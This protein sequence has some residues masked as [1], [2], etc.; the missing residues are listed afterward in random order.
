ME[1][2]SPNKLW[3]ES[4][5]SL[6]FADWIEREKNKGKFMVNKKFEVFFN[7]SGIE[8]T[9]DFVS[10]N[11]EKSKEWINDSIEQAKINLGIEKTQ[12]P[13]KKDTSFIGLNKGVLIV[14]GLIILGA[15]AYKIYQKRK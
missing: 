12:E 3:R 1:Q 13:I 6:S 7:S 15:V 10:N 4:G 9:K 8:S 11:I 5:T 14:S 2:K